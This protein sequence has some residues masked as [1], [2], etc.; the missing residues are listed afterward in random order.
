MLPTLI[1]LPIFD[2]WQQTLGGRNHSADFIAL[3]E[4]MKG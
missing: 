3:L 2:S 4:Q 1:R